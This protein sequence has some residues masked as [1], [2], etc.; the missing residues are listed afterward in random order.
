M[1]SPNSPIEIAARS[2]DCDTPTGRRL[3]SQLDFVAPPGAMVA[4]VG[5]NGA[6]KSTLLRTLAGLRA[7]AR[8][9]IEGRAR[10][11]S[12]LPPRARA[13]SLAYLP[14]GADA[15]A[16]LRVRELVVLGRAPHRG[17]LSS[18]TADD[19]SAAMS[20]LRTCEVER[21]ADRRLGTL[22]GGERQRVMV[23]RMLATQCPALLLDEPTTALDIGHALRLL[24]L[25]RELADAEHTVVVAL[26]E[27]ELA[28]RFAT[29]VLCLHGDP[30]GRWSFGPPQQ[31]LVPE[32]LDPV[33]R[34]ETATEAGRLSFDIARPAA[35]DG[36][37]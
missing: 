23:A 13:Q 11:L 6:G 35:P 12:T 14:Q 8:G 2:V 20:A 7:P 32:V 5:P 25:L 37:G 27:L 26:H 3:V 16:E 19:R 30:E 15:P 10:D 22:S 9:R 17:W 36:Q 33:F 28:R 24:T 1:V 29:H 18:F 31:V 21:F 4:I 34:V